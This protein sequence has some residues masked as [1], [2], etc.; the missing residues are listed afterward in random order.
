MNPLVL[1]GLAGVLGVLVLVAGTLYWH[2]G[3]LNAEVG[4]ARQQCVTKMEKLGREHERKLAEARSSEA[5]AQAERIAALREAL[6]AER[7]RRVELLRRNEQLQT[8]FD[9][10]LD[11]LN[12]PEVE[13]WK[14]QR[15]P[16][17]LYSLE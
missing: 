1:K 14:A 12:S 4:E 7:Q 2:N 17:E 5:A 11:A 16:E 6:A 8:E 13:E 9:N 3:R 15:L 10:A